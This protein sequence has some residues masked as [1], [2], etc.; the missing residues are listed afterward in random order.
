[1]RTKFGD[2]N[3]YQSPDS[4]NQLVWADKDTQMSHVDYFKGLI[5]LRK[6]HAAFRMPSADL[7]REH[8]TFLDS[9]SNTVAYTI[10]DAPEETWKNIAVLINGNEEATTFT[11]P[12]KGWVVVVNGEKAG[13]SSLA[14]VSGDSITVEGKTLVVLVDSASYGSNQLVLWGGVTLLALAGVL[15]YIF[16]DKWLVKKA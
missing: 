3:S 14:R 2:H 7:I 12:A 9:P 1:M 15:A 6:N 4:I 13:E 11:L 5:N 16:K 8:L 10:T